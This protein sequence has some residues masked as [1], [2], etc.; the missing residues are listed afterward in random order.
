VLSYAFASRYIFVQVEEGKH[1][2]GKGFMP[3]KHVT[4]KFILESFSHV[5][6]K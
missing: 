2:K 6:E 5:L 1:K 4:L 3:C